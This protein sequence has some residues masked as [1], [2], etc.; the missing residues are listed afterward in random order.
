LCE[1]VLALIDLLKEHRPQGEGGGGCTCE[2]RRGVGPTPLGQL[3]PEVGVPCL[4]DVWFPPFGGFFLEF[5]NDLRF[6]SGVLADPPQRILPRAPDTRFF[7]L[8]EKSLFLEESL[9]EVV[10]LTRSQFLG[11]PLARAHVLQMGFRV[12]DVLLQPWYV[13][14]GFFGSGVKVGIYLSGSKAMSGRISPAHDPDRR[15]RGPATGPRPHLPKVTRHFGLGRGNELTTLIPL[16]SQIRFLPRGVDAVLGEIRIIRLGP[17]VG[18]VSVLIGNVASFKSSP[19]IVILV[20]IGRLPLLLPILKLLFLFRSELGF[21]VGGIELGFNDILPARV[22]RI[23]GKIGFGYS[24]LFQ[25]LGGLESLRYRYFR[26]N[27]DSL[28]RSLLQTL[29]RL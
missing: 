14:C 13:G 4:S 20:R 23:S 1:V 8:I 28:I 15:A 3:H 2:Q 10:S 16:P 29:L 18:Q 21:V 19:K 9:L 12:L 7:G 11:E 17:L 25:R 27:I 22:H 24:L 5:L 6:S 26:R